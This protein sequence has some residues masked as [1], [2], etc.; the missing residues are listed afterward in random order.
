MVCCSSTR[1]AVF[2]DED[3]EAEEGVMGGGGGGGSA[4]VIVKEVS[5]KQIFRGTPGRGAATGRNGLAL[6]A[7]SKELLR[8]FLAGTYPN[9]GKS[10]DGGPGRRNKTVT[11]HKKHFQLLRNLNCDV[12]RT[13]ATTPGLFFG[14]F[15]ALKTKSSWQN[16]QFVDN[17]LEFF[18]EKA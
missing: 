18:S 7:Q 4:S 2:H 8:V 16:L 1:R 6:R 17:F 12:I 9:K 5:S 10:R 14:R 3:V 15:S 13:V 11:K